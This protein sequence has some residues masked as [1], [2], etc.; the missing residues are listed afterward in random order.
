MIL[1]IGGAAQGKKEYVKEHFKQQEGPVF[2]DLHLWIRKR[3]REGGNPEQEILSYVDNHRNCILIC[4][5]VGNGIV[6]VDAFE[7][8]YRERTGRIQVELAKRADE[9]IRVLCGVGQR[10]K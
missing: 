7:R 1:V 9:V 5:E 8:E 2:E 3:I 10:I 6:P 4:D